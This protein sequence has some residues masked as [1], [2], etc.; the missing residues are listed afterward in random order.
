MIVWQNRGSEIEPYHSM[1][2]ADSVDNA[3]DVCRKLA[4]RFELVSATQ[5]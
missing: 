1:I 5:L 2:K 3:I 4:N